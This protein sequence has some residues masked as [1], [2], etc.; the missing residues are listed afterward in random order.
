MRDGGKVQ[1]GA[2]VHHEVLLVEGDGVAQWLAGTLGEVVPVQWAIVSIG[3]IGP[4][5]QAK[6]TGKLLLE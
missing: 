5:A 6:W 1:I 3:A 4:E 2:A